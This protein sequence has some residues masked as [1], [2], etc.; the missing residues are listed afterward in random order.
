MRSNENIEAQDAPECPNANS[1]PEEVASYAYGVW[2]KEA[3]SKD[4]N[5]NRWMQAAMQVQQ[6]PIQEQDVPHMRTVTAMKT[7][8]TVKAA[9]LGHTVSLARP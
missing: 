9:R 2:L 7:T 6:H 5:I 8:E 1:T 4:R 3:R